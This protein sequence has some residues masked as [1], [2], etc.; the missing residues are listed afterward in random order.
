[1]KCRYCGKSLKTSGTNLVSNCGQKCSASP[2][3]K[4]LALSDGCICVYCGRETK[5]SGGNLITSYGQK[6]YNSPTGKH[7]LQ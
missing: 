2:T 4:H 5:T 6:C 1:M 3:Q 7:I